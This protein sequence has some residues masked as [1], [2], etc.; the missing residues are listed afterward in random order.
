MAGLALP[1]RLPGALL[2][3]FLPLQPSPAIAEKLKKKAHQPP[4]LAWSAGHLPR[5]TNLGSV[6]LGLIPDPAS[7][8]S[9][10]RAHVGLGM[11]QISAG[12]LAPSQHQKHPRVSSGTM[13][14]TFLE[15]HVLISFRQKYPNLPCSSLLQNQSR[16]TTA[17]CPSQSKA[18]SCGRLRGICCSQRSRDGQWQ[19]PVLLATGILRAEEQ[20]KGRNYTQGRKL[21]SQREKETTLI[22]QPERCKVLWSGFSHL[23]AIHLNLEHNP[24]VLTFLK[25]TKTQPAQHK[26]VEGAFPLTQAPQDEGREALCKFA[27]PTFYTARR[28]EIYAF[29]PTIYIN[30]KGGREGV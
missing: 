24:P 11:P 27:L 4:S 10:P 16:R 1:V 22:L 20:K 13:L 28:K 29:L 9:C 2:S 26:V 23:T 30:G 5:S 6:G 15:I 3:A 12:T 7:P 19:G 25:D 8:P 21:N 14:L 17:E 18:A